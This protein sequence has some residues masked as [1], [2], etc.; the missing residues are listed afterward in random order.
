MRIPVVVSDQIYVPIF[1]D[2]R[3]MYAELRSRFT[4]KNPDYYKAKSQ[5]R[6]LGGI[7]K[8]YKTWSNVVHPYYGDC[9]ALPRGGSKRLRNIAK[10]YDIELIWIDQRFSADPIEEYENN[11]KLWPEQQVLA[12]I[13]IR[14][15]NCLIRSPTA[16]GKTETMLKVAEWALKNAGPVLVIVWESGLFDQWV[17]RICERFDI[18]E[19][20]VGMLGGGKKRIAPITVGMQQTLKNQGR[21]YVHKFGCVMCDEIQRFAAPTFQKA[22]SIFPARYRFGASADE[23]VARG[24]MITLGNEVLIPIEKIIPGDF[25]ATPIG[26]RRVTK[27]FNTGIRE[28]QIVKPFDNETILRTTHNT[29]FASDDDWHKSPCHVYLKSFVSPW[30]DSTQIPGD[31]QC[32]KLARGSHVASEVTI[33]PGIFTQTFDLEVEEAHCYYANNILV[34]N[35]RHDGKEFLIYDMFGEVAGEVEKATLI[36][37]G[38][39]MPTTIRLIPTNFDYGITIGTEFTRW[40]DLEPKEK[41]FDDMLKYLTVDEDRIKLIWSFMKPCLDTG[42]ILL[43][44]SHRVED[45]RYWDAQIREAGYDCGLMLGGPENKNEF[46]ATRASLRKR[47]I[48]AGIGTLQKVTV[49]HDIHPLDRGFIITPLAQNKQLFDQFI[50]RLRRPCEGKDNVIIY[51]MWDQ[52]MYPSHKRKIANLYKGQTQIFVDGEFL[53]V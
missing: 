4:H 35:S 6:W 27:V 31:L 8:T 9:L 50:G 22:V 10:A 45:A 1:D 36:N 32:A 53:E 49:G 18:S 47:L 13:M 14:T 48:Q 52:Y 43:V 42:R 44:G 28:T 40:K 15:E 41:N 5:N 12:E 38:K 29:L 21:R 30:V 11:V 24:T 7:N 51:Y 19:K 16:S 23:C 33:T 25:V 3:D 20:Q 46:R 17:E 26:P 2:L 39:I 37:K 34:H